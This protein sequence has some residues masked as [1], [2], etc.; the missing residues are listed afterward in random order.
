MN[1]RTGLLTGQ[2]AAADILSSVPV[3]FVGQPFEQADQL[4]RR[5]LDALGADDLNSLWLATA[6]AKQSGLSR[7]RGALTAFTD[8]GGAAEAIVGIDEGGAS[9]E[10]LTLCLETFNRV[11][12]FHDPGNRTFHPKFYAVEGARRAMVMVGSGNLTRGGLFTNY[13]TALVAD[14]QR[15]SDEWRLRDSVRAYFDRLLHAG[16]AIRVL[17]EDLIALLE[18]EGWVTSEARQNARRS[19]ESRERAE[20]QRIFGTPVRGL[21]GAPPAELLELPQEDADDD[22]AL[23]GDAA[24]P[25]VEAVAPG[26][27][28]EPVEDDGEPPAGTIGFWKQL[29][30]SDASA[31]SS[32]GQIIIPI[33]YRD[34]FPPLTD[35]AALTSGRGSGQSGANFGLRFVEG[36]FTKDVSDARIVLYEPAPYHPRPNIELR[37]TFHDREVFERLSA[38]DIL[39]FTRSAEG[40]Y[41]VERRP[42]GSLGNGRF[43]EL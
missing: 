30:T 40:N 11:Y 25:V 28:A 1:S 22:S 13:E 17:D 31:T 20:R 16:D 37:F 35:E 19:A 10:G 7:I 5:L 12:V 39:V 41:R 9:R 4:G 29:S 21:A 36:D 24:G 3:E 8:R 42:E 26:A 33:R 18:A 34:F 2:G 6:W 15:D 27:E 23:P 38:G 32:P 43:G 14:V